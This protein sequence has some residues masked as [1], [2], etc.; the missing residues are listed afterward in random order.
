MTR[1]LSWYDVDYS[2]LNQVE[3]RLKSSETKMVDFELKKTI[4]NVSE[5]HLL[6]LC[7]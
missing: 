1:F 4:Y 5:S 3:K 6:R 7:L 2:T